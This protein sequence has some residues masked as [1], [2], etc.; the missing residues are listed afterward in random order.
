M[1]DKPVQPTNVVKVT[2]EHLKT[3]KYLCKSDDFAR[4]YS[5]FMA[6]AP[7]AMWDV[8]AQALAAAEARGVEKALTPTDEMQAHFEGDREIYQTYE[9]DGETHIL[10]LRFQTVKYVLDEIRSLTALS[11]E[12]EG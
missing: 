2:D 3:A 6:F 5:K 12:K 8:I 7:E 11:K 9:I 4:A 10:P 1:T